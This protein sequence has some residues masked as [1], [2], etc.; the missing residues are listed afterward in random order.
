MINADNYRAKAGGLAMKKSPSPDVR[1]FGRA[2]WVGFDRRRAHLAVDAGRARAPSLLADDGLA[3]YLF[4][5]DELLPSR[6]MSSTGASSH[7][8]SRRCIRR[9]RSL[10]PMR[11]SATISI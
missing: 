7:S 2:L 6:A 1:D 3:Q 8:K 10:R 5:I 11:D 9:S 4:V